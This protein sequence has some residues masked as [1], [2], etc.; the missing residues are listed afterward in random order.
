MNRKWNGF[1][2]LWIVVWMLPLGVL[3]IGCGGALF[4]FSL[5][6][7]WVDWCKDK[8]F[9]IPYFVLTV[10]FWTIVAGMNQLLELLKLLIASH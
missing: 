4:W 3:E 10:A 9:S 2:G 1:G 7:R 5:T 6:N 8:P